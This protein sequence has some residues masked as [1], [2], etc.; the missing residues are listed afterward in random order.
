MG[1]KR[2]VA[3]VAGV[4][5]VLSHVIVLPPAAAV[6]VLSAPS[7]TTLDT[8]DARTGLLPVP[9]PTAEPVPPGPVPMPTAHPVEPG[10]VPMPTLA[11]APEWL[12]P[13][14]PPLPP[15]RVR[16]GMVDV[17]GGPG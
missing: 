16:S 1:G 17:T 12:S 5:A 11:P 15:P 3:P 2:L 6:P 4:L 10:P 7:V 9:M 8:V 14:L 13:A